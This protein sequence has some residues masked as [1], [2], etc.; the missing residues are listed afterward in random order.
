MADPHASF[1]A[2]GSIVDCAHKQAE[3]SARDAATRFLDAFP[4]IEP[5]ARAL[6]ITVLTT[7]L[8]EHWRAGVLA[9]LDAALARIK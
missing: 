3:R 8:M 5:D 1:T 6:A 9:G 7:D 2:P 4:F